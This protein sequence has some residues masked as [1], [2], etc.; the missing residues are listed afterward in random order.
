MIYDTKAKTNMKASNEDGINLAICW[1]GLN[2]KTNNEF[3]ARFSI[4]IPVLIEKPSSLQ[5]LYFN[6]WV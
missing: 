4:Y 6:Y 5:Q 2:S 3:E 1:S